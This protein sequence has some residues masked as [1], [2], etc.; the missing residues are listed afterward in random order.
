MPA[1]EAIPNRAEKAIV[2]ALP[3]PGSHIPRMRIDVKELI[4]IITLYG[5]SLSARAFGTVRPIILLFHT[6]VSLGRTSHDN[7]MR[8]ITTY[9]A[10]FKMGTR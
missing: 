4:V 5:P 9:L 7:L 10:P 2:V 3:L 8:L 1:P 6:N